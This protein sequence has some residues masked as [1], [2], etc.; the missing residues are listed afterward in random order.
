MRDREDSCLFSCMLVCAAAA[1]HLGCVG[2]AGLARIS[3]LT[4]AEELGFGLENMT[5]RL[6]VTVV[7]F[8]TS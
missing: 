7:G 2:R 1:L 8:K 5:T 4:L 3:I 6:I